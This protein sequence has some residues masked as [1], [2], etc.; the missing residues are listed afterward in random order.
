MKNET[1]QNVSKGIK[2]KLSAR[3]QGPQ[4]Q[5]P[6]GDSHE[7]RRPGVTIFD[8]YAAGEIP[9]PPPYVPP[10]MVWIQVSELDYIHYCG[11]LNRQ[12]KEVGSNPQANMR[13]ARIPATEKLPQ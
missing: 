12:A 5:P 4:A 3:D 10:K 1:K 9:P 11:F 2:Q 6:A 7:R 8:M 13:V